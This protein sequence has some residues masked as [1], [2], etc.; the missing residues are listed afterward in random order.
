MNFK[1]CG[2]IVLSGVTLLSLAGCKNKKDAGTGYTYNTYLSTNPKTWN[3][4][5]WETSDESYVPAFT[6]MGLYDIVWD[7]ADGYKVMPEMAA[8][9]QD[10]V[11]HNTVGPKD[12]TEEVF[13]EDDG[14]LFEK[15]G[16]QGNPDSGYVWD[17]DLNPDAVWEDGTPI[18]ADTYV[19]SMERLLNP[20][21][22]NYRA[23]SW[24]ANGTVLANAERYYKQGRKTLDE[25][26]LYIDSGTG[27]YTDPTFAQDG[28]YYINIAKHTAYASS[29]FGD[30]ANGDETLYT[31]TRNVGTNFGSDSPANLAADRIQD[32]ISY[33]IWKYVPDKGEYASDWKE[34]VV[35]ISSLDQVD[36]EKWC[37]YDIGIWEFDDNEVYVRKAHAQ[38]MTDDASTQERYSTAKLK[39]DLMKVVGAYQRGTKSWYWQYPLFAM[40]KNNYQVDFENVGIEKLGDYKIRLYLTQS[41]GQ[42][43]LIF[44]LT[45]NWIVKTDLYDKLTTTLQTGSKQTTYGSNSVDNYVSYGPYKLTQYQSGKHILME[46]NE[47]WYGYKDGHHKGQFQMTAIDTSIIPEH[48][49]AMLEF[50]KGNLD[51]IELSKADMPKYGNS[52]RKTTTPESYTQ[53]V[54]FNT[55]YNT[56]VNRQ[57]GNENKTVLTNLNFR[58]GLSLAID[59][60]NFAA[61][62]TAGSEGFTALLNRMYL[63]NVKNGEAYRDTEPGKKVYGQVYNELGGNPYDADYAPSALSEAACGY[64]INM[65]TWYVQKGLE[66]ELKSDKAGHIAN[67]QTIKIEF[68]VY[69]NTSENTKAAYGR[70]N[71]FWWGTQEEPGVIRRAQDKIKAANSVPGFTGIDFELEMVKDEDYYTSASNGQYDMIF[72]IWG[73][74]AIAPYNLMQ[75]YCDS[76]FTQTCEYGFK[77]KQDKASLDIDMNGDGE[78]QADETKSFNSWYQEMVGIT[79]PEEESPEAT[80]KRSKKNT[81]LGGLEA[82]ILNR[83][84]AIPIVSR[85]ST[86]ITSWKVE[87]GTSKYIS[88]VGYGGVRFMTF[89]YNDKE[90][91]EF[92][93]EAGS[94]Y[95]LS[96]QN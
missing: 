74:A 95:A 39:E 65:A 31:L 40:K 12:V 43:D 7:G 88:L 30:N 44:S 71:A 58:K 1:K 35:G 86:S 28:N 85:S 2:L 34:K 5:D 17:I 56:L 76:E 10:D 54:S 62:A 77:G 22:V 87:N 90:W 70:L 36:L 69:D 37:N 63:S 48:N 32:A 84:E 67:G 45:G 52:P 73:G 72:S 46:K 80:A 81:I 18:N 16:Y 6:E 11:D 24:Y 89:N 59:R 25:C 41:I 49:T 93:K 91:A 33:Y 82:G 96:Y 14:T 9:N 26:F 94:D 8:W 92:V 50:E 79:V 38:K 55:D 66:E 42:L 27:K 68:R 61:Q 60:N 23:D 20:K 4:H 47:N 75:V 15:Y 57:T 3:T 21:L 53:K 19:D 64:N 78:I 83:F 13:A 29:P 51:D